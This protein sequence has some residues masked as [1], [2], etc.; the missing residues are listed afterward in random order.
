MDLSFTIPPAYRLD[1]NGEE[2]GFTD[3]EVERWCRF[4]LSQVKDKYHEQ[5]QTYWSGHSS[6]RT[7]RKQQIRLQMQYDSAKPPIW[8]VRLAWWRK[9]PPTGLIPGPGGPSI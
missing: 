8:R 7:V 3:Q 4:V 2:A 6:T 9:T 1:R 5:W